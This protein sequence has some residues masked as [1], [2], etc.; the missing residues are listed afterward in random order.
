MHAGVVQ[1]IPVL[2]LGTTVESF[3]NLRTFRTESGRFGVQR[4]G[5]DETAVELQ[6]ELK[7]RGKLG[8]YSLLAA[9]ESGSGFSAIIL[10]GHRYFEAKFNWDGD[11]LKAKRIKWK[12]L[13][14]FERHMQQ[15]LNGD[16]LI[17]GMPAT[18]ASSELLQ[19][20]VITGGNGRQMYALANQAGDFYASAGDDDV[21]VIENFQT[22]PNGDALIASAGSQYTLGLVGDSA[23]IYK[24]SVADGDLVA[25]LQGVTPDV[26][27]Q[28]NFSFV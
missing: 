28:I 5:Q 2:Q 20:D 24:G 23:G 19:G 14:K 15:D 22:G 17:G 4:I 1:E 12:K 8:S 11:L 3:G 13:E 6:P 26:G 16:E 7:L 18:K 10:Q 21:L 27:I 9:E 25:I